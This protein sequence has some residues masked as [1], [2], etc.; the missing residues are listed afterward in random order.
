[1]NEIS[2]KDAVTVTNIS[3]LH[4]GADPFGIL[5]KS[6]LDMKRDIPSVPA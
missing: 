5:T 6:P 2:T 4:P 3:L 1:M